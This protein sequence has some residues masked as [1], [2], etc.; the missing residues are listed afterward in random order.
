MTDESG[1]APSRLDGGGYST[2]RNSP[3][4]AANTQ[5][6][7]ATAPAAAGTSITPA[8]LDPM[9]AAEAMQAY[10]AKDYVERF[11]GGKRNKLL[12]VGWKIPIELVSD[13]GMEAALKQQVGDVVD[14]LLRARLKYNM[15]AVE[16]RLR[17]YYKDVGGVYPYGGT[18]P[19]RERLSSNER[20]QLIGASETGYAGLRKEAKATVALYVRPPPE[21]PNGT[22]KMIVRSSIAEVR[23]SQHELAGA[24]AHELAHAYADPRWWDLLDVMDANF[25]PRTGKL[26]EGIAVHFEEIM[27]VRWNRANPGTKKPA[28]GYENDPTIAD[29]GQSFIDPLETDTFHEAYFAGVLGFTDPDN[30]D[31]TIELG[32][33]KVHWE[34][35]WHVE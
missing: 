7:P 12:R 13:A 2:S 22:G 27:T 6:R 4:L 8:P 16:A 34:W 15:P 32:R 20:A 18:H 1:Y 35:Q 33:K 10:F 25:L 19:T 28:I 9:R 3:A 23:G 31:K 21:T 17:K 29:T 5:P 26:T 11:F 14:R 30:P 24:M